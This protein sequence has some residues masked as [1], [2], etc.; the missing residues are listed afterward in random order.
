MFTQFLWFQL[1]GM[2]EW[3]LQVCQNIQMMTKDL[4]NLVDKYMSWVVNVGISDHMAI[5]LQLDIDA[6]KIHYLIKFNHS[7]IIDEDFTCLVREKW[8]ELSLYYE[9]FSMEQLVY[10]LNVIKHE[11][12]QWEKIK[13]LT[14]NQELINIET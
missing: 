4:T 9:S 14:L 1:R 5:C 3:V 13:K 6:S 11:V 12:I 10:K 8:R 7:L 2:G